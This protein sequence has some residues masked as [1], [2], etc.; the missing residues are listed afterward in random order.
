MAGTKRQAIGRA[1]ALVTVLM[2]CMTGAV[3]RAESPEDAAVRE[4]RAVMD[5]FMTAFNA[6]DPA[7]LAET[8]VYPH[9]RF[10]SQ[11]V[12]VFPDRAAF[13][14]A[15]DM[16]AFARATGWAYS[17]WDDIQVIHASPDKVHFAVVF[18]RLDANDEVIA[19][20]R[21]LYVLERIEGRWG[22]RARSS[23]AP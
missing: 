23:F 21:S 19:P 14:A 9:V 18:T 22:I 11:T 20:Y 6:S 17:R 15:S 1:V 10:A 8:L 13:I 12:T 2:A 7:A 3:V 4:A 16:A 5:A